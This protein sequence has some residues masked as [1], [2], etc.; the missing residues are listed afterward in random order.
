MCI[1]DKN[2]FV[3]EKGR[4]S[5][6]VQKFSLSTGSIMD[7]YLTD[8][9]SFVPMKI[10]INSISRYLNFIYSYFQTYKF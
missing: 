7:V 10:C 4:E 6:I 3:N 9:N 5:G 2:F 1:F 8:N